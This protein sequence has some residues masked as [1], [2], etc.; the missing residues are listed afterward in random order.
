M[1][2]DMVNANPSVG[3]QCFNKNEVMKYIDDNKFQTLFQSITPDGQTLEALF[4]PS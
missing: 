3:P 2:Y 1:S 4:T